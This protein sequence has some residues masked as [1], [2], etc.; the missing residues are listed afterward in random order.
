[1]YTP[2]DNTTLKNVVTETHKWFKWHQKSKQGGVLY[3]LFKYTT[4]SPDLLHVDL[5]SIFARLCVCRAGI[6]DRDSVEKIVDC[7][8]DSVMSEKS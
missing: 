7:V 1:M 4:K 6:D 8:T 2:L 3:I 5:K